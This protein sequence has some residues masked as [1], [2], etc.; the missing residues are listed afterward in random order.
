VTATRSSTDL[1]IG[2]GWR[3]STSAELIDV[4]DPRTELVVAQVAAGSAEDADLACRAAR[5][6]FAD[7]WGSSAPVVRA[8]LLQRLHSELVL[9]REELVADVM[10]DL[11]VPRRVAEAVQVDLPLEVLAGFVEVLA[12]PPYEERIGSSLVVR[13]P[14]GVV[15]ALTPWN[16]PL[17]QVVAKVGAALAAGCTVVVKPSEVAPL[18]VHRLFDA[19]HAAGFPPGVLN[20]ISGTGSD[21]GSALVAHHEID[22]VSFTGSLRGGIEVGQAASAR[23]VP[24]ILEL[25]GKSAAVVLP[26]ADLGLAVRSTAASVL[27]NSGQTCNALSLLIVPQ[28]RIDEAAFL[29]AEHFRSMEAKLGPLASQQQWERVQRLLADSSAAGSTVVTGGPGRPEGVETGFFVRPTVLTHLGPSDHIG[30]VEVFGPVLVVLGYASEDEAVNLANASPY[31][32]S[33][34]VWSGDL[35][36]AVSFAR[37]MRTGQVA[38]NGA[39]FN[40]LAPFG[41]VGASGWGRELGRHG[42]EGFS[43][44]KSLQL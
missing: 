2:G 16:Y 12:E 18:V 25:G 28:D 5:R 37:R 11:G 13:E 4:T 26:D 10:L 21:V 14:V 42:I 22:L 27:L 23:L 3:A 33:G 32:L 36:V 34:A 40:P 20:L 35:D 9:R 7:G 29:A 24:T 17:H 19:A 1:Y 15:A 38:I 39:A 6:A 44:L 43:Y 31:G 8:Q 41:G 30:G